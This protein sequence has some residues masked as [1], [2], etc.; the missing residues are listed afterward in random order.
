MVKKKFNWKRLVGGVIALAL[1]G[2]GISALA[3]AP[4]DFSLKEG[5][6]IRASGDLDIFIVNEFGY[7]RL[8]IN[9]QIFNLYGHLGWDKVKTVTPVARDAFGTSGLFRVDGDSK[10]YV[11]EVISGDVGTLHWLNMTGAQAV[12][13]DPN[14]AKKVFTINA[15]EKGLYGVG[16]DYTSLGG[17]GA[18]VVGFNPNGGSQGSVDTWDVGSAAKS[19]VAEGQNDVEVFV[20]EV[21]LTN[22]GPLL[23]KNMD[24]W[25]EHSGVGSIKPWDY[26]KDV[27]LTVGGKEV[28]SKSA[29]NSGDWLKDGTAYRLRFAGFD[30]VL[31]SDDITEVG[32]EV[33]THGNIDSA[34]LGA[35][36]DVELGD[37]RVLDESGFLTSDFAGINDTFSV[38]DTDVADVEFKDASNDVVASVVEV[39]ETA[40]TNGVAIYRATVEE[41]QGTDVEITILSVQL[42]TSD[43]VS[44]V[45]RKAYLFDEIGRAHV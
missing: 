6:V 42:A 1:L 22:D 15:L 2:W 24:V 16:A 30:S 8:F 25:F 3:V 33:S 4:A 26:F 29:S 12:A 19:E 7:K 9:P 10:V 18:P 36:W 5:D 39:S 11:L 43:T 40:D 17:V 21:T 32:V 14:F 41:T 20:G 31:K 13:Q 45:F 38:S 27:T 37:Y 35:V 44:D 34:D 28:G 23:L